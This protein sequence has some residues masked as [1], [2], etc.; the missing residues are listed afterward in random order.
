MDPSKQL[1]SIHNQIDTLFIESRKNPNFEKKYEYYL[2]CQDLHRESTKLID[3]LQIL[4]NGLGTAP[5]RPTAEKINQYI[6]LL[7]VD[8]LNF[9]EVL[10]I[11]GELNAYNNAIPHIV[12][13]QDNM[14]QEIIYEEQDVETVKN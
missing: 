8:N 5:N 1:I 11:I 14:D 2:Q 6:E 4:V 10:H 7:E 3:E 9:S 13:V 12:T